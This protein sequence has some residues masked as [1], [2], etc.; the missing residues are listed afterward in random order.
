MIERL[1][2]EGAAL[3]D[4]RWVMGGQCCVAT[5][6]RRQGLMRRLYDAQ[7]QALALEDE[8]LLLSGTPLTSASAVVTAIDT[9]NV[10]SAR[11]EGLS[12]IHISEPTRLGMISYAVF[13][14]KKKRALVRN[15]D[16]NF[17]VVNRP[18]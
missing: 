18:Y 4:S 10:P 1:E 3:D 14:L 16:N 7:A 11:A 9:A 17:Y 13:C 8:R 12:L 5:G 2:W 15:G 6:W